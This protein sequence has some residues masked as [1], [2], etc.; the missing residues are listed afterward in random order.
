MVW[1]SNCVPSRDELAVRYELRLYCSDTTFGPRK[2]GRFELTQVS[3]IKAS[4]ER[5]KLKS[6]GD[7]DG[8]ADTVSSQVSLLKYDVLAMSGGEAQ[9]RIS[10]VQAPE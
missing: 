4:A 10:V 3:T 6:P 7:V 2:E 9:S 5:K 8:H 1:R